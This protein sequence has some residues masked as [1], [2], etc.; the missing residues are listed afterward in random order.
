M[1]RPYTRGFI[2][3]LRISIFEFRFSSFLAAFWTNVHIFTERNFQGFKH[4][5]FVET[6]AL[7]IGDVTH[8]GAKFSIGPEEIADRGEQLLD[9]IVLLDELGDVAGGARRGNV[10]ERLRRLRIKPNARHVLR[11]N[12]DE[13]Q[14]ESL[15]KIGDELVARH[16]LELAVV[17]EALLERQMPV[18]VV[19]IPPSVLQAL[20]KQTRLADAANFMPPCDHAFL[21]VLPNQFAQGMHKFRLHV[22]EPLVVRTQIDRFIG[23]TPIVVGGFPARVAGGRTCPNK[24]GC[25]TRCIPIRRCK[26]SGF[27]RSNCVVVL[28]VH[29]IVLQASL[30]KPGMS[31]G[32]TLV[33]GKT[34]VVERNCFCHVVPWL[35]CLDL[36]GLRRLILWGGKIQ[37]RRGHA[38]SSLFMGRNRLVTAPCRS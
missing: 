29:S 12:S 28:K 19:G 20:P 10:R 35:S 9:V 6:K 17:A 18:H 34:W 11:K 36:R 24:W 2:R 37:K 23:T 3:F 30:S 16:L 32:S 1:L 15:I 33:G 8:V 5:F 26:I 13:R 22:F 27:H 4:G 38:S 14:T 31:S 21:A 25:H 7:A